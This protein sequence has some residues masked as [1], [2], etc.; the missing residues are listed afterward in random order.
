MLTGAARRQ[1]LLPCPRWNEGE[2]NGMRQGWK[3]LSC[4]ARLTLDRRGTPPPCPLRRGRSKAARG[5]LCNVEEDFCVST[6]GFV[7][8]LDKTSITVE[9]RG[10][11]TESKVFSRHAR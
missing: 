2:V 11:K 5:N 10:K 8:A 7:T 3:P 1:L 4:C 6:R 9:K